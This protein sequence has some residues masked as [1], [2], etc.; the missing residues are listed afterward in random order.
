M[1]F[2]SYVKVM[3][4]TIDNHEVLVRA[5]PLDGVHPSGVSLV[6]CSFSSTVQRQRARGSPG[7]KLRMKLGA[8][9]VPAHQHTEG[10]LADSRS[11]LDHSLWMAHKYQKGTTPD[12]A[13]TTISLL[14]VLTFPLLMLLNAVPWSPWRASSSAASVSWTIFPVTGEWDIRIAN[15]PFVNHNPCVDDVQLLGIVHVCLPCLPPAERGRRESGEI[16]PS[17]TWWL[18]NSCSHPV[19]DKTGLRRVISSPRQMRTRLLDHAHEQCEVLGTVR[20]PTLADL[21]FREGLHRVICD[22]LGAVSRTLTS[23]FAQNLSNRLKVNEFVALTTSEF[24]SR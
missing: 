10:R 2:L 7:A 14:S 22:L 4:S 3:G 16:A 18:P 11:M 8:P 21:I 12:A 24:V 19:S 9:S 5:G 17:C 6:G 15:F 20:R 13:F 23:E 1:L